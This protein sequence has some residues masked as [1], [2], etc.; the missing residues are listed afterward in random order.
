MLLTC[1]VIEDLESPL[2]CKKIKPVYPRGHQSWISTGRTGAEAETPIL[3]PPDAKNQL[4][5][6]DPDAGKDWRQEEKWTTKDEMVRWHH[7]L[8]GHEFEQVLG[9]SEGQ[10]N[11]VCYS[12]WGCKELG[13]NE[14][15]NNFCQKLAN[16]AWRVTIMILIILKK[17]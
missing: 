15:L 16:S 10:G 14:C 17:N 2:N 1:G 7:R 13:I 12:P 5:R 4:I 8:N 6:K 9:D 11:L 3:W